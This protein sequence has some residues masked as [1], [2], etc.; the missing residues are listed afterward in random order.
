M[1]LLIQLKSVRR[2]EQQTGT[3][4]L[5]PSVF[6]NGNVVPGILKNSLTHYCQSSVKRGFF[7]GSNASILCPTGEIH[8]G[9]RS[10]HNPMSLT[11]RI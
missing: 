9:P 6:D 11:R 5:G 8:I 10:G 1:P 7:T 3:Q 4:A 2:H